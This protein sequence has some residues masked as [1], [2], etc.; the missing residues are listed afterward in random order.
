MAQLKIVNVLSITLIAGLGVW[1]LADRR[2]EATEVMPLC[3]GA[4]AG[5]GFDEALVY[6]QSAQG[7][8]T[9]RVDSDDP[10]KCPDSAIGRFLLA[11]DD[12]AALE[13]FYDQGLGQRDEM[14]SV[15]AR[16]A[17]D[18]ET[19][20]QVNLECDADWDCA[21]KRISTLILAGLKPSQSLVFCGFDDSPSPD[22][23]EADGLAR[24][25]NPRSLP[26][27][28]DELVGGSGISDGWI[29]AYADYFDG[30]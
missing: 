16:Y 1:I 14:P 30:R 25:R 28:C 22:A 26:F 6:I 2:G 24:F 27:I 12:P 13:K 3:Q 9:G 17:W 5:Q 21:Q 4:Q 23:A 20:L 11:K 19:L 15:E 8:L 7:Y 10:E 18:V 29:S